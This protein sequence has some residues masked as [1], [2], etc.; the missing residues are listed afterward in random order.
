MQIVRLGIVLAATVLLSACDLFGE[1]LDV[2]DA[3]RI[4]K[5][6]PEVFERVRAQYP[7]PLTEP[8]R[9][10]A[11]EETKNRPEDIAFLEDLR[12]SIPVELLQ[13]ST[14]GEGGP[15]VIRV[16]MG[17]YGLAVS[18][19]TVGVIYF[20][21]FERKNFEQPGMAVFESCDSRAQAWLQ[22]EHKTSFFHVYCRLTDNWY[23]YEHV[24]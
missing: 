23:A 19:S 11:F 5:E 4:Y 17:A 6:N 18:G 14:W 2:L 1:Q 24:T 9:I 3:A 21:N 20:E 13:V 7:G 15:D 16:V 22:A 12:E 8:R 10:P